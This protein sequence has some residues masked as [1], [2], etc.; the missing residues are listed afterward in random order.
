MAS[1]AI[2]NFGLDPCKFVHFLG[3]ENTCYSCN[4]QRTLSVVKDHI[5][6]EDLAHMKQ[7]LLDSCPAES[8]FKE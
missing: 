2:I 8:M 7:I 6:P 3:G 4:V 1:A 5:S